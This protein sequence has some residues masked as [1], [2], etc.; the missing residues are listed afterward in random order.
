MILLYFCAGQAVAQQRA[1][2][3]Q[4]MFEGLIINPAY[5][6][7]DEALSMSF[8]LR[9]Q[10]SGVEGAPSTQIFSAHTLFKKKQIGTGLLIS[11]D[12]IGVHNDLNI[13]TNYAYHLPVGQSKTLSFGLQAGLHHSMTDYGALGEY[14]NDPGLYNA[15]VSRTFFDMGAGL[16][17][18]SP[19]LHIGFS[20]PEIMPKELQFNDSLAVK[21]SQ[22]NYFFFS[23]YR[24]TLDHN[25]DLEPNI[26]FKYMHGIPLSYDI[27]CSI[28]YR[29]ILALGLSYR[30]KESLDL[31]FK[32]RVTPQLQFGYAYDYPVGRVSKLIAGSH[33]IAVNYLF[34][35]KHDNVASPR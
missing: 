17:F 18:K 16:Y 2:F 22:V 32:C 11:N 34:R 12:K 1:Q 5:A 26:L 33:E 21:I 23:K 19:E 10:W 24:L 6:G 8:I 4:Y 29:Q 13:S 25:L 20:V 3:T 7:A 27:N 35:F 15:A 9:D 30:R 31:I 28:V 14:S